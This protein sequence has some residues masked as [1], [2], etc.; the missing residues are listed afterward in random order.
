M[1]FSRQEFWS[2]LP[3]P[4]PVSAVQRSKSAM[5][6]K[7][8]Q[9]CLTLWDPV[10]CSPQGSSVHGILQARILEWVAMLSSR[11]SS[12]PRSP[13][14]QADSLPLG[15]QASHIHP[16]SWVFLTSPGSYP[17]RSSQSTELS[18]CAVLQ[19]PTGYLFHTC[20]VNPHLPVHPTLSLPTP[21]NTGL[22]STSVTLL[23][24]DLQTG[25]L[26]IHI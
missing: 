9:S 16:P 20:D 15:H 13:T 18:S 14:L 17:S 7:S 19:L 25:F 8:L 6:V 4:S 10:D 24:F 5:H 26:H 12:Q 23:S 22:F 11:G 1:G 21:V 2:G 3:V